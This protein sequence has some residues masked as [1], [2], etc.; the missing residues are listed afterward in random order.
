MNKSQQVLSIL[1]LEALAKR[2][3]QEAASQRKAL[4]ELAEEEF[5][6]GTL[7]TWRMPDIGRVQAS[8]TAWTP[9]VSDVVEFT[10]W[11]ADRY[12]TEVED[13]VRV[14]DAW[15]GSFLAG[16]VIDTVALAALD[17]ATDEAVPGLTVRKGGQ[18]KGVSIYADDSTKAAMAA[19]A[20][21]ELRDFLTHVA[22]PVVLAEAVDA[23][24]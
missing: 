4:A 2:L 14:R 13:I 22:E 20:E 3:N 23:P 8:V 7:P 15:L 17:P 9:V 19:I 12:P 10:K 16:V 11:V 5:K 6:S 18:F 24:A 21:A 1:R